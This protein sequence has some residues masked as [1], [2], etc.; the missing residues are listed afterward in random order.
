M[1]WRLLTRADTIQKGDE[2]LDDDCETWRVVTGI[3]L[4]MP[5]TPNFFLPIRRR[6]APEP[7]TQPTHTGHEG[8]P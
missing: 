4:G 6:V 8:G 2:C 7:N 5:Y 3:C 1:T